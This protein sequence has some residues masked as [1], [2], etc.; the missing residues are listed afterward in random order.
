MD[1]AFLN[2]DPKYRYYQCSE[3]TCKQV[4]YPTKTKIP[5]I[6]PQVLDKILLFPKKI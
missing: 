1:L 3:K 2:P 6:L 5:S 4:P